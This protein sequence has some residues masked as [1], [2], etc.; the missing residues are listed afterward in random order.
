VI[1]DSRFGDVNT[2]ITVVF[3]ESYTEYA[4]KEAELSTLRD[5]RSHHCYMVNSV[6]V[7]DKDKLRGFADD[8][9][10]RAKYLF[11]TT[12]SEHYYESFGDDWAS[13]ATVVS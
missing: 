2:D 13:F 6:P 3:E 9:S 10:K 11:L 5:D 7:M 8:L 1:P 12:N 4:A